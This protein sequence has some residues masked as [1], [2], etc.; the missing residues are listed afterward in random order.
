MCTIQQYTETKARYFGISKVRYFGISNVRYFDPSIFQIRYSTYT[1]IRYVR[2]TTLRSLM[3]STRRYI[4]IS[5]FRV[6]IRYPRTE[7][8]LVEVAQRGLVG[9]VVG[10]SPQHQHLRVSDHRRRV[11][12][13]AHGSRAAPYSAWRHLIRYRKRTVEHDWILDRKG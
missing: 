10:L 2:Y 4:G 6:S 9:V 5:T 12:P 11:A 7:I 1:E 3:A 8:E 13:P